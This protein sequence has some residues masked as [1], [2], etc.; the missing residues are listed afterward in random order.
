MVTKQ[1]SLIKRRRWN[2]CSEFPSASDVSEAVCHVITA[3]FNECESPPATY[4]DAAT[5]NLN[6][7]RATGPVIAITDAIA[8]YVRG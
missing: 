3:R 6:D 7:E 8:G 4:T 1:N 5:L 2:D